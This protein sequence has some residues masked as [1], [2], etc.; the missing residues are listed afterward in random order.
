MVL[1]QFAGN[2]VLQASQTLELIALSQLPTEEVLDTLFGMRMNATVRTHKVARN[3]V[4]STIQNANQVS[5][6]LHAVSAHQTVLQV[7]LTSVFHAKRIPTEEELVTHSVV[8]RALR[9]QVLS[10]THHAKM[11]M[12]VMVQSAGKNAQ[13]VNTLVVLSALIQLTSALMI[14]R[15][16]FQTFQPS[17]PLSLRPLLDKRSTCQKSSRMLVVLPTN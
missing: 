6:M 13:R 9:S 14:S 10:A 5:T 2:T 16:L 11:D 1:A 15:L 12:E 7:S 17:L 3:G 4:L 8:P